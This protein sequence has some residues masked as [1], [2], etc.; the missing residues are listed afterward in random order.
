VIGSAKVAA[1]THAAARLRR[2][3]FRT[4]N[5]KLMP[6]FRTNDGALLNRAV[7]SVGVAE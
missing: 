7:Y 5:A 4:S 6:A 2:F 3:R 1:F